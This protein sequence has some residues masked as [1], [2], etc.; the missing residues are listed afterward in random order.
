VT[1]T[2]NIPQTMAKE[3]PSSNR[4]RRDAPFALALLLLPFADRLRR[5]GKRFGRAAGVLLLA[6]AGM[7]AIMGVAGCASNSGFF[8]QQQKTYTGTISGGSG[9]LLHN[10]TITLIVE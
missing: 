6:V 2:I 1:L 8:A 10:A 9:T 5:A 3:Q 4:M 7:A